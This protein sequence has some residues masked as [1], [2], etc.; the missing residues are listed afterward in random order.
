MRRAANPIPDATFYL[1]VGL[2]RT[3]CALAIADII[4]TMRP[5]PIEPI[6]G[7]PPYLLG[8]S[9]IRGNAVPVIDLNAIVCGEAAAIH[10]RFVTVR[11]QDRV[12]ALAVRSVAGI[13]PLQTTAAETLVPLLQNTNSDVIEAISARDSDFVLVLRTAHLLSPD[14]WETLSRERM[15][16]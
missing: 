14:E 13:V 1:I 15:A 10:S 12:A 6:A 16:S 11:V 9:R 3:F 7:T 5:L 2:D 8:L 4:E